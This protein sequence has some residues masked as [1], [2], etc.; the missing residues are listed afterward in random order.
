MRGS[1]SSL[2]N[3]VRNPILSP[4]LKKN[5]KTPLSLGDEGLLFVRGLESNPESS[6]KTSQEA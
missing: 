1:L 2:L 5:H 3:L 6:L 4:Q